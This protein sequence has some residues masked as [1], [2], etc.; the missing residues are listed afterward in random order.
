M[1]IERDFFLPYIAGNLGSSLDKAQELQNK[2]A[3]FTPIAKVVSH[4][5]VLLSLLSFTPLSFG[6][7]LFV[8]ILLY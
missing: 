8:G 6:V 1:K 3:Q 4:L 2:L 7:V 5:L